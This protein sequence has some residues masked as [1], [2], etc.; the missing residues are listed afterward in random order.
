MHRRLQ[1][2]VLAPGASE[3]YVRPEAPLLPLLSRR[4]AAL[5]PPAH[6]VLLQLHASATIRSR[7]VTAPPSSTV[8]QLR[9]SSPPPSLRSQHS[10]S[11]LFTAE[12]HLEFI[13]TDIV[14]G[15]F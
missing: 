8:H 15:M 14:S 4:A 2:A 9:A 5:P 6:Q 11:T 13:A 12:E 7:T 1:N 3:Q 10:R